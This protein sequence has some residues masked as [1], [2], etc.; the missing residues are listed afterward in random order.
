MTRKKEKKNNVN[1]MC[2]VTLRTIIFISRIWYKMLLWKIGRSLRKK[3]MRID[4]DHFHDQMAFFE[5]I[6]MINIV[7]DCNPRHLRHEITKDTIER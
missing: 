6:M 5:P 3:S 4:I 7:N 2:L 1:I